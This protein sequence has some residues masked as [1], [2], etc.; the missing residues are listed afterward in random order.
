[1]GSSTTRNNQAVNGYSEYYRIDPTQI[2]VQTSFN[3]REIFDEEKLDELKE[4]IIENGVLV[5]IRVKLN[6]DNEFILID[7]E[8]RLR[9]TLKAIKEGHQIQ[10]I[11]A[12]VERKTINEIDQLILALNTNT[13]EPLSALEEAK[14]IKRLSNYGLTLTDISKKLGKTINVI[15]N[16]I[17][18]V[19]ASPELQEEIKQGNINIYQAEKII[20]KSDSIESQKKGI[21]TVKAEKAEKKEESKKKRIAKKEGKLVYD[22]KDFV[23]LTGDMIEWLIELNANNPDGKIK[24][25]EELI[26]KAQKMLDSEDL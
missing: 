6:K 20:R 7:G 13:G 17:A 3:P 16:R 12:I 25:V 19:D 21:E 26:I 22:K 24:Q 9:A 8:R 10:S 23:E 1:M 2:K 11:P 18:L 15:R 5:P 4:S 14:A